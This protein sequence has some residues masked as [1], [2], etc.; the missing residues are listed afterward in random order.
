TP[1]HGA[2]F[3]IYLPCIAEGSAA[4]AADAGIAAAERPRGHESILF[5]EDQEQVRELAVTVLL[6][7]GGEARRPARPDDHRCRDAADERSG[8]GI[9]GEKQI[10]QHPRFIHFGV[11]ARYLWSGEPDRQG[12]S[13]ACEA[14]HPA[15]LLE[16]VR[17]A[18]DTT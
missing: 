6:V 1:G 8:T 4:S 5:V 17:K 18:L 12:S 9:A 10:T 2:T 15:Q 14:L 3:R 7:F 16:K 11:F 13:H